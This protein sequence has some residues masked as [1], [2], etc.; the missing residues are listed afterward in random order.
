MKMVWRLSIRVNFYWFTHHT[1]R[2]M[3]QHIVRFGQRMLHTPFDVKGLGSLQVGVVTLRNDE[4]LLIDIV[5]DFQR[6]WVQL[7]QDRHGV[8]LCLVG[9]SQRLGL[10]HCA[11]WEL[12]VGRH[13]LVGFYVY[14]LRSSANCICVLL[15][16]SVVWFGK[17]TVFLGCIGHT[18]L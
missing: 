1:V 5:L 17:I 2:V 16:F 15:G 8:G 3:A 13:F 12:L 14:F 9:P 7:R 11:H 4:V 6:G 10:V 18:W